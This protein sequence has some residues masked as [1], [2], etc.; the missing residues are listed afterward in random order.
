MDKQRLALSALTLFPLL[1]ACGS[2]AG[3]GSVGQGSAAP[4]TGVHWNVDSLTVDGRTSEAPE[5]AYL[6]IDE[7]GEAQGNYG[8]NDFGA[9]AT[10]EGDRVDIEQADS[11]AM[12]CEKVPMSFEE[13]LARTL[14]GGTL[15]ARVNDGE[16][17]L[18]TGDGDKIRLSE[19]RPA[20]LYG[21]KWQVTALLDGDSAHSLPE[22]AKGKAWLTF[23]REAGT[24]SGSLGCN[25]VSAK[26]TV[27]DATVRDGH[28]TLGTP[29][30]T[31]TMCDGSL[32][33]TE[34]SLLDLFKNKV[35]YEIDHRTITLTSENGEGFSAVANE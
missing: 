25:Q 30:T 10:V 12:A 18:T 31:R 13:S 23:D 21:T 2:E 20:G 16:L 14:T 8:C 24:V 34:Q 22:E 33:E 4:V 29:K 11:T 28:I 17:T 26:A 1:V 32:M 9:T 27:R 35:S 3:S 19:E 6:R 15:T 7:D 5:G